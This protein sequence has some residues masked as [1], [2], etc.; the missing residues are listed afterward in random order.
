MSLY[1]RYSSYLK[2][3]YGEKTYK[4][5]VNLPV[6]CPNR[7]GNLGTGGCAFCGEEAA[8]FETLSAEYSVKEQLEK[9]KCYIGDKYG[10]ELFIA[11]FQNFSN[12]YLPLERLMNFIRESIE[13][14]GIVEVSLS[15]RPDCISA[16]Y[17][18]E[19]KKLMRAIKPEVRM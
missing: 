17:M 5:P 6:S 16:E 12:T 10:A 14:E 8:G 11:Y 7:D 2:D 1:Y 4:L 13:I 19:I 3:K 15:T 9:N 18:R